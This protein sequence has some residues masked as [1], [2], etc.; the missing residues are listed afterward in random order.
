MAESTPSR[1]HS[2]MSHTQPVN[3][4]SLDVRSDSGTSLRFT[5]AQCLMTCGKNTSYILLM[6]YK[7]VEPRSCDHTSKKA[8][9]LN[10]SHFPLL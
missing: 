7:L 1:E 6:E 9:T 4:G 5:G 2:H 10:I 8:E 3:S